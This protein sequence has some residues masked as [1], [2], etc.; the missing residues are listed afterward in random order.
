MSPL[1]RR[2]NFPSE[3]EA[4]PLEAIVSAVARSET[5]SLSASA[6]C[7][8]QKSA[9]SLTT[10]DQKHLSRVYQIVLGHRPIALDLITFRVLSAASI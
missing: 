10:L 6:S 2:E 3:I 7:N 5:S 9:R 8:M 4:A 1:D